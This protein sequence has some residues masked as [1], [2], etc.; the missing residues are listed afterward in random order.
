M[1]PTPGDSTTPNV[2][3]LLT[4]NN[5]GN[6]PTCQF[7]LNSFSIDDLF[8]VSLNFNKFPLKTYHYLGFKQNKRM[9]KKQIKRIRKNDIWRRKGHRNDLGGVMGVGDR[10]DLNLQFGGNGMGEWKGS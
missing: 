3:N 2:M 6:S 4:P 9:K 5:K 8:L 1:N 7:V 10:Y